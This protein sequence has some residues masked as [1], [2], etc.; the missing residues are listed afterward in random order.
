[1]YR[2]QIIFIK[3]GKNEKYILVQSERNKSTSEHIHN[4]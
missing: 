3:N 4:S 2:K 1:M